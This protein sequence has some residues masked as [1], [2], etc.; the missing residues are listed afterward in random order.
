MKKKKQNLPETRR[1]L[2]AM[3]EKINLGFTE[4]GAKI[5]FNVLD[6]RETYLKT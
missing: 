3:K 6:R 2:E 5:I 1:I 4:R